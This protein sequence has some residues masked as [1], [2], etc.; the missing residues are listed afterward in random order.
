MVR[1]FFTFLI[2]LSAAF[3]IGFWIGQHPN[4]LAE[5]L[6]LKSTEIKILVSDSQF[7]PTDWKT[8]EAKVRVKI[9]LIEAK[10]FDKF[11]DLTDS[12]DLIFA[13]QDWLRMSHA[14]GYKIAASKSIEQLVYSNVSPDFLTTQA[15][16]NNWI[17]YWW[18]IDKDHLVIFSWVLR[19]VGPSRYKKSVDLL[20]FL[21]NK[22][23]VINWLDDVPYKTTFNSLEESSIKDDKKASQIRKIKFP[24]KNY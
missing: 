13:T 17:P 21:L 14:K 11:N 12:V 5:K 16:E 8:W 10:N 2:T 7:L 24:S 6:N 9:D 4:E 22:N 23:V 3:G 1:N 18:T 15:R 19:R 20:E